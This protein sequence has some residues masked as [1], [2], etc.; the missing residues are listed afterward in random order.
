MTLT[1]LLKA[2]LTR[3]MGILLMVD[4]IVYYVNG[5]E[6]TGEG[7]RPLLLCSIGLNDSQFEF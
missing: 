5:N 2:S 1:T 4:F 6:A 3:S 7:G